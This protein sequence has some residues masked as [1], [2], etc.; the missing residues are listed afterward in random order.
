MRKQVNRAVH[1]AAGSSLQKLSASKHGTA[2]PGRAYTVELPPDV[3]LRRVDNVQWI[4]HALGVTTRSH[5]PCHLAFSR[6]P[7]MSRRRAQ[8]EP[9]TAG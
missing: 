2:K 1:A 4:I 5:C 3:S 7:S 8:H 6:S 9:S